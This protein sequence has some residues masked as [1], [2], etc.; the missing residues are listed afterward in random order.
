MV[1]H[2]DV[3]GW[4]RAEEATPPPGPTLLRPES[5]VRDADRRILFAGESMDGVL[6]R[7]MVWVAADDAIASECSR[8][9][10]C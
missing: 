6:S 8:P 3:V 1:L 9:F 5:E 4:G 2:T 10:V 7:L